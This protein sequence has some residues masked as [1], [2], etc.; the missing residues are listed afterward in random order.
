MCI[1]GSGTFV[2]PVSCALNGDK[3][4]AEINGEDKSGRSG[5]VRWESEGRRWN[6]KVGE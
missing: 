3:E 4:E 2:G 5:I 6:S 1:D